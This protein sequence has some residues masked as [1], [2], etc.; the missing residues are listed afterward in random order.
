MWGAVCPGKVSWGRGASWQH[1]RQP[2][3]WQSPFPAHFCLSPVAGSQMLLGAPGRGPG[4]AGP[5]TSCPGLGVTAWGLVRG[6]P[7]RGRC[8]SHSGLPA[9]V[10]LTAH[11]PL[12]GGPQSSSR[13]G[14]GPDSSAHGHLA[15]CTLGAQGLCCGRGAV[16]CVMGC[17]ATSL[18]SPTRETPKMSPERQNVPWWPLRSPGLGRLWGGGG[19]GRHEAG[20]VRWVG[21]CFISRLWVTL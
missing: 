16:L 7:S 9:Q 19:V 13:R 20:E 5:C 14:P 21:F 17:F 15:L 12:L 10:E 1:P 2:H 3:P 11:S 4:H 18:V 6:S 8:S